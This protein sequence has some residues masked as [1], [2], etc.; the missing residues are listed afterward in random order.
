MVET[1][2]KGKDMP[3][4]DKLNEVNAGCWFHETE[5]HKGDVPS[6][7]EDLMHMREPL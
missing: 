1:S 5:D 6:R 4:K 7:V 2:S 3:E